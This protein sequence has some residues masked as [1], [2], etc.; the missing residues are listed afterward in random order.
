[1]IKDDLLD[2][3]LDLLRL[4]QNNVTFPLDGGRLELGILKDIGKNVDAS[5][6]ILVEGLREVDGV[7]TLFQTLDIQVR[8]RGIAMI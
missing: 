5:W 4:A 3:L 2:L 6:H 7:L 1:M 8:R